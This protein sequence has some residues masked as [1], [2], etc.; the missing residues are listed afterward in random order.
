MILRFWKDIYARLVVVEI[1]QKE[2]QWFGIGCFL[3]GDVDGFR[4]MD[5][6]IDGWIDG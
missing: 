2:M 1:I 6:G 3:E 4:L 5:L